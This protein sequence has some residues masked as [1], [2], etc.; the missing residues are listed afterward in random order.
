VRLGYFWTFFADGFDG[1]TVLRVDLG[2]SFATA[3]RVCGEIEDEGE[4][5]IPVVRSVDR[6]P[7]DKESGSGSSIKQR[8]LFVSVPSLR[9]GCELV[10]VNEERRRAKVGLEP[11]HT[12]AEL[13]TVTCRYMHR[14]I[15]DSVKAWLD[16]AQ[17]WRGP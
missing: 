11:S 7:C 13:D 4:W 9:K 2:M 8:T 15:Q 6:A 10:N 17:R 5:L 3:Q 14:R 16:V 1:L 12:D